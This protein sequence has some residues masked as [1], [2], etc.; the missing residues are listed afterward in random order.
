MTRKTMVIMA[1]V[2]AAATA[3]TAAT[4]FAGSKK[5]I[6]VE[7]QVANSVDQV[8]QSMLQLRVKAIVNTYSQHSYTPVK[9][10]G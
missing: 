3:A 7:R 10:R 1:L 8:S 5:H 4:A 6:L 2:L 9:P